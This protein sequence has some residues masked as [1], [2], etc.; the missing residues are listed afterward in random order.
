M[1]RVTLLLSALEAYTELGVTIEVGR[2]YAELG[3]LENAAGDS[4]G[5]DRY[6]ET[7]VGDAARTRSSSSLSVLGNLAES[8]EQSATSASA[9][10]HRCRSR[11]A[12]A[13]R[14]GVAYM[15]LGVL[16]GVAPQTATSPSAAYG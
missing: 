9:G 16:A 1:A 13:D 11:A 6:S 5:R 3:A 14:D 12:S 2:V 7:A 15:S 8:Y 4:S 10:A